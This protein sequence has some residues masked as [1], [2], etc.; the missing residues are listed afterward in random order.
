MTRTRWL[1]LAALIALSAIA[2]PAVAQ[3]V[4][5]IASGDTPLLLPAVTSW[6]MNAVRVL[7][8]LD[9]ICIRGL[10]VG[11]SLP[12]DSVSIAPNSPIR[13]GYLGN[14]RG[15]GI[16][17]VLDNADASRGA[18]L[19]LDFDRRW[20]LSGTYAG[21]VDFAPAAPDAG[22]VDL[23]VNV[24]DIILWPLLVL[25]VGVAAAREVQR[26]LTVRKTTLQLLQRL[27]AVS[28]TFA[29]L[30]KSVHGYTVAE[31][32]QIRRDAL[33]AAIREWDR[34]HYGEPTEG[35][36]E[37]LMVGLL[38]PLADLE[39]QTEVWA[40]FREKLDRLGRRLLQDARPVI[41]QAERP[42][43]IEL[44]E[45][46]FYSVGRELLRGTKLQMPQVPTYADRIDKAA[47]LAGS[48]GELYALGILVRDAIRELSKPAI[49]LSES[50]QGMLETARHHLNSAARDLWEATDLDD[51]R[52]REAEQELTSAQEL[53][54]R[55]MD[56]FVYYAGS[57]LSE[58]VEAMTAAAKAAGAESDESLESFPVEILGKLRSLVR[59]YARIDT[60][61]LPRL[62][63]AVYEHL[64]SD[65]ERLAYVDHA[66][67][68]GERT[69][70]GIALATSI[71]AGLDRYF[72]T[73]FG[74]LAD[75]LALLTWGLAT[76]AG[77]ELANVVL[78]KVLASTKGE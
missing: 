75:Y 43:D 31:D 9:P 76:K 16:A 36:R 11:C 18:R 5:P 65:S 66:L 37:A 48:W 54:R 13:L 15:G 41:D 3:T 74:S 26:Y 22:S 35:E 39:Q 4:P 24:K 42:T 34:T 50:E 47:D 58:Q 61:R 70:T 17:V 45:P 19:S 51:L 23:T 52:R 38:K 30:R 6:T 71:I 62:N 55:L 10:A 8:F 1:I 57:E 32:F 78:S 68:I 28:L 77:L 29:K 27:N 59:T 60:F 20:G 49:D 63:L 2:V 67:I 72:T 69:I 73:N 33:D 64:G 44:E 25:W 21:T 40:L 53:T 46:R 56:P 14:V 7:P 12:L